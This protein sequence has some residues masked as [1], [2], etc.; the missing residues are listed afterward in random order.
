MANNDAYYLFYGYTGSSTVVLRVEF[1][2]TTAGGYR[3]RVNA[4]NNA[5]T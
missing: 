4:L 3:V 5:S 1:S 2:R